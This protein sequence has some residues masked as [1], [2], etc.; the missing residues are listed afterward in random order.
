LRDSGTPRRDRAGGHATAPGT[1]RER[2]GGDRNRDRVP[3]WLLTRPGPER[4]GRTAAAGGPAL[5][6]R[7]AGIYGALARGRRRAPGGAADL[8]RH[9]RRRLDRGHRGCG[10]VPSGAGADPCLGTSWCEH[11]ARTRHWPAAWRR[12]R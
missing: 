11:A 3:R 1:V 9:A 10:A 5:A 6:T 4:G 2:R 8:G 7:T 12:P